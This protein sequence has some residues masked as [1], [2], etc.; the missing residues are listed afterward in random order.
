MKWKRRPAGFPAVTQSWT[1]ARKNEILCEEQCHDLTFWSGEVTSERSGEDNALAY[2]QFPLELLPLCG[3]RVNSWI[4]F[5]EC[6]IL[7][8]TRLGWPPESSWLEN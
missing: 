3:R 6:W 8:E 1:T 7:D 4:P 2:D 5:W